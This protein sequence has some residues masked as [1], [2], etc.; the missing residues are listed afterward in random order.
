M[1]KIKHFP[2]IDG[3]LGWYET[4]ANRNESLGKRLKGEHKF[5][6]AIIGAGFTG[7]SL[8]HRLAEINPEAKIALID[9]LK[10][11]QGTSG[12]NAGFIIDLPH[13]LDAGEPDV[14]NN[15]RL[16]RL[17]N[18]AISRLKSF[19]ET[20]D[21][22]CSWHRAGKFMAAHEDSNLPGLDGF[23]SML[24][25]GGF[26]YEDLNQAETTKRLG[27]RYYQRSVYTPGNI[28]INPSSLARGLA[29]ALP[30]S[31]SLFENSPV[32]SLEYGAPHLIDSI[33]GTIRA[34]QLVLTTNSY[35]EEFGKISNRLAPVFTYG[36]LTRQLSQTELH[37]H[38]PNIAP[39]GL[40]SAHPAGTTVRLTSD[41]RIFIRNVLD[42]EPSLQSNNQ[43]LRNAWRQH[44]LSYEMR[45]PAIKTLDFEYTWGGMLCMTMNHQSVFRKIENNLFTSGGCNGV[46]VAKGTYLGYYL[47][48]YMSGIDSPE[49]RY[50]LS[51]SSPSWV[52][53]EPV[54]SIGAKIR[55]RYESGK[56][57]GDI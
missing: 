19:C 52:P 27:T 44:R 7:L 30:S 14:E 10:V 1:Q 29:K 55:L 54:R 17:N 23:I 8:A 28:L 42:F 35:T 34:T 24:K 26:E 6:I 3:D 39:W 40:T 36:S 11:G 9:A 21:I 31:V 18:F 13:N 33:G 45:F 2:K 46:G 47:A 48:D 32:I 37:T 49:L 4:A 20:F 53:P 57:G 38:F 51:S 15:K 41:S 22:D 16:Y 12:R 25:A 5:D 56:A 43:G 50:I